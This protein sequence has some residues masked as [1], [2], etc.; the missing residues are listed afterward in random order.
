M[1]SQS[2]FLGIII[3]KSI[4][5]RILKKQ[6]MQNQDKKDIICGNND[7]ACL[8]GENTPKYWINW[9]QKYLYLNLNLN[10]EILNYNLYKW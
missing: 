3:V 9:Y 4:D 7:L 2:A 5:R 10:L 6:M 1:A 8:K